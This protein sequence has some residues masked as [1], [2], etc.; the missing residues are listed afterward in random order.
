ME[1]RAR[2]RRRVDVPP[3]GNC[4]FYAI[5]EEAIRALPEWGN[6]NYLSLS[7]HLRGAAANMIDEI[8]GLRAWMDF[9]EHLPHWNELIG[10]GGWR[11]RTVDDYIVHL[12]QN[13]TWQ[14]NFEVSLLAKVL[15]RPIIVRVQATYSST[16]TWLKFWPIGTPVNRHESPSTV[17]RQASM[18]GR[19]LITSDEIMI[20]Y[21]RSMHYTR[22]VPPG[23]ERRTPVSRTQWSTH[24]KRP[25]VSPSPPLSPP[26]QPHKRVHVRTSAPP[27]LTPPP[28]PHKRVHRVRT[29]PSP[30]PS[31]TEMPWTDKELNRI[32]AFY[33]SIGTTATIH[34][35]K[36]R[37]NA[38]PTKELIDA[39]RKD[40]HEC[41]SPGNDAKLLVEFKKHLECDLYVCATCGIRDPTTPFTWRT[42][43]D[44][45]PDH[46]CRINE[47]AYH[48]RASKTFTLVE[49]DGTPHQF[50]EV[51]G[52]HVTEID[53][54][55]FHFTP[56]GVQDREKICI[57]HRCYSSRYGWSRKPSENDARTDGFYSAHAPANTFAKGDDF[58]RA[59]MFA[60]CEV[61]CSELENMT[62]AS[63]RA[64]K[65]VIQIKATSNRQRIVGSTVIFPHELEESD[66]ATNSWTIASGVR[67]AHANARI[68]TVGPDGRRGELEK[69]ALDI[70]D[71]RLRPHVLHNVLVLRSVF[72]DS[73]TPLPCIQDL[74]EAIDRMPRTNITMRHVEHNG[75]DSVGDIANVR[76]QAAAAGTEQDV[77]VHGLVGVHAQP[78]TSVAAVVDG[79]ADT[80]VPADDDN[81]DDTNS[82][83]PGRARLRRASTPESD[84]DP[85]LVRKVWPCLLATGAIDGRRL[86]RQ[87]NGVVERAPSIIFCLADT[88][89]RHH[90]NLAVSARV[91]NVPTA[92]TEFA[93][94][95][96]DEEFMKKLK[97][98]RTSQSAAMSDG[99]IRRAV[100]FLHLC[101]KDVPWSSSERAA[102]YTK[103]LA[104]DRTFGAGT[105]FL[106]IT[107]DDVHAPMAI[108]LHAKGPSMAAEERDVRIALANRTS[109][110]GV[111]CSEIQL[112]N[113]A[114]RNAV[115]EVLYGEHLIRCVM[116]H[117]IGCKGVYATMQGARGSNASTQSIPGA[118]G[119]V[120]AY[121]GVKELNDREAIH[122]HITLMGGLT[123]QLLAD[124]AHIPELR[125][126]AETVLD[127]IY[128]AELPANHHVIDMVRK[129]LRQPKVRPS[130]LDTRSENSDSN[131]PPNTEWQE[132]FCVVAREKNQ[133]T[134]CK[135]CTPGRRGKIGCRFDMKRPHP[136]QSSRLV[137][138]VEPG[139]IPEGTAI[140]DWRCPNCWNDAKPRDAIGIGMI[141]SI[142]K[143]PS[144]PSRDSRCLAIELKRRLLPLSIDSS[145]L[146]DLNSSQLDAL[147]DEDYIAILHSIID[148]AC[149][150]ALRTALN[151]WIENNGGK[152]CQTLLTRIRAELPC[153]NSLVAE[154]S[155]IIAAATHVHVNAQPLGAGR[156][157]YSVAGYQ[158]SY[159]AKETLDFSETLAL[160]GDAITQAK[161]YGSTADNNGT[162]ERLAIHTF[163]RAINKARFEL[164]LTQA[165]SVILNFRS[166]VCSQHF[167]YL[168][169]WDAVKLT[170]KNPPPR[171]PEDDTS[172]SEE[173]DN[174][175]DSDDEP[176]KRDGNV[177]VFKDKDGNPI[178][179]RAIDL[180]RDRDARLIHVSFYEFT[181]CYDVRKATADELKQLAQNAKTLRQGKTQESAGHPRY[182]RYAFTRGL[183]AISHVIV[184]RK[185]PSTVILCGAQ[186]PS[187]PSRKSRKTRRDA[188]AAYYGAL[189]IPWVD[190]PSITT[191]AAWESWWSNNQ[192]NLPD[193]TS[194]QQ[195]IQHG[196][197]E[198]AVRIASKYSMSNRINTMHRAMR[199]RCRTIWAENPEEVTWLNTDNNEQ[200]P[201]ALRSLD[202]ARAQADIGGSALI[203]RLNAVGKYN[204][205]ISRVKSAMA[206]A[207]HNSTT[208]N[209]AS[210]AL[211][212][213]WNQA[214]S[215][216]RRTLQHLEW[217]QVS[218][219]VAAVCSNLEEN[220]MPVESN[221][222]RE[223]DLS[224][225]PMQSIP[226]MFTEEGD[227]QAEIILNQGQRRLGRLVWEACIRQPRNDDDPRIVLAHGP[228]G[229]GKSVVIR[230]L[231]KSFEQSNCGRVVATAYTGI[232]AAPF[233]APTLLSLLGLSI[234]GKASNVPIAVDD[235]KKLEKRNNFARLT[236]TK[237][238]DVAVLVIDEVSFIDER[239]I[240]HVDLILR[241]L[242][243]TTEP[244]GGLVVLMA[245]DI[246]QKPPPAA[247]SGSPKEGRGWWAS[248]LRKESPPSVVDAHGIR[249]LRCMTKVE[250]TELMR[251]AGDEAFARAQLDMRRDVT[252]P[253]PR[254]FIERLAPL[255]PDDILQDAT[256]RFAPCAVTGHIERDTIN[257]EQ[258]RAFAQ[259]FA[260]P[261]VKWRVTIKRGSFDPA[262]EEMLFAN[263]PALWQYYAEG[264]PIMLTRNINPRLGIANG[265]PALLD[266]MVF[267]D[268]IP[269]E[270]RDAMRCSEF[271]EVTLSRPPDALLIRV[272]GAKWH[273]SDLPDLTLRTECTLDED[274]GVVAIASAPSVDD[275]DLYSETAARV[276]ATNRISVGGFPFALAFALTDYKVQGMTLSKLVLVIGKKPLPPHLDMHGFYVL[277]SRVRKETSL[278]TLWQLTQ[279]DKNTLYKLAW[280]PHMKIWTESWDKHGQW[281]G[282]SSPENT[283]NT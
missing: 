21:E 89:L 42:V 72:N 180:Y 273:G 211:R 99:V 35:S 70:A 43:D 247:K 262:V 145:A 102:E 78:S 269:I 161:E 201:G 13:G 207:S 73:N 254:D 188:F 122:Y 224:P 80:M 143:P 121:H 133:H 236:G 246:R 36:L 30:P 186:P 235:T 217:N 90:T 50:S 120:L 88:A 227:P 64:Y 105:T 222:A 263:E 57:C 20:C 106:T 47:Q 22:M 232:A 32:Q 62:I 100:R 51:Q 181:A 126:E 256:W 53:G 56:C 281:I 66:N 135:A 158:S 270:L 274:R 140:I 149:P 104:M 3:D 209:N 131:P 244:F 63:H 112:Q 238:Q 85:E 259:T 24:E 93:N 69:K 277:I 27:P 67:S 276:T 38:N 41:A 203:K 215:P 114:A 163:Q 208:H 278:R 123:P 132:H 155:P 54:Q 190:T 272:T 94:A 12:R 210:D 71:L 160:M 146:H 116:E 148:D 177:K 187:W 260:L 17:L 153:R 45:P 264:A 108:R 225:Q 151:N 182:T 115:P 183:L 253:I 261:L 111:D 248:M 59:E 26:P 129:W 192:E 18:T 46:W 206:L 240:G 266:S 144:E 107:P 241:L 202:E 137:Q 34:S 221:L 31:Q 60:P 226:T 76:A 118:F 159:K 239:L 87:Y 147:R 82:T 96:N 172:S 176:S 125:R 162:I 234:R 9:G 58:L 83:R 231:M 2:D 130:A 169:P 7:A 243:D 199:A 79:I 252:A 275:A 255:K 109:W 1:H 167:A 77:D 16:P 95:L 218:E 4:L 267:E 283:I 279:D 97:D 110:K 168:W 178:P 184:E 205:I 101:A 91:K 75:D 220:D 152:A 251:A 170:A 103:S 245:G 136:V 49:E 150:T 280:H 39:I 119:K 265:S 52:L 214:A 142:D 179:V 86:L 194:I 204:N 8:E 127:K 195:H 10:P 37:G 223:Q 268:G 113:A 29:C 156:A 128:C 40:M 196:R 154:T 11:H 141:Q 15:S 271:S 33:E 55:H 237:L 219:A 48:A 229:T 81:A 193:Q 92:F 216:H 117:L 242:L 28:Q 44:I 228:G 61:L 139:S 185:R 173:H 257:F 250:L 68:F 212:E 213:Q 191:W 14:T 84:Y 138:L 230:A 23:E 164:N 98:A 19:S 165:I 198:L 174:G 65:M 233:S 166:D 5:A 200:G 258:V 157:A 175:S 197:R 189:I 74:K 6:W 134:H 282:P 171:P 25:R 249:A 124:I